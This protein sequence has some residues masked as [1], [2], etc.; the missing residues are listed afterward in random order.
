VT[1]EVEVRVV[2][3]VVVGIVVNVV[4]VEVVVN[5][6]EVPTGT[7]QLSEKMLTGTLPA[8]PVADRPKQV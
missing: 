8:V 1:V 3:V 4:D 6:V 7:V 5:V 2:D